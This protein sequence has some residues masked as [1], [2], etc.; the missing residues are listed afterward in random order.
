MAGLVRA[1][2]GG[3]VVGML[4]GEAL[5]AWVVSSCRA[6]GLPV[7]LTDGGVIERVGVL[8]G[9]KPAGPERSVSAVGP[10]GARSSAPHRL[11]SI[12]VDEPGSDGYL[13]VTL[14]IVEDGPHD[15]GLSV[16]VEVGPLSA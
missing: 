7:K 10:S 4:T 15:G 11:D 13:G 14:G 3:D 5:V 1:L 2:C 16:E 9:G 12:G 6:Q 8:L